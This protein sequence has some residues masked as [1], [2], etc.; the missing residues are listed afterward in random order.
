MPLTNKMTGEEEKMVKDKVQEKLE[1][2]LS[3]VTDT[4]LCDYVLVMLGN[5]KNKGQ[6]TND[7]EVP[8]PTR[9]PFDPPLP[10]F[11]QLLVDVFGGLTGAA[12]LL[13]AAGFPRGRGSDR[14]YRVALEAPR[15]NRA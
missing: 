9:P 11:A 12:A 2:Y 5:K 10:V 1:E 3:S 8:L 4:V 13:L 7:L 6:V 14:I 15:S